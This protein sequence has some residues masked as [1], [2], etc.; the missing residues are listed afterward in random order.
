MFSILLSCRR[1][2]LLASLVVVG[3]LVLGLAATQS[4][5]EPTTAGF[6]SFFRVGGRVAHPKVYRLADLKA[7][8]AHTVAVSFQGPGGTQTHAFTGA[9]MDDVATAAAPRV[10]AD[11]KNDILRWTARVHATDNYEVVVAW[12]EFDPRFEAKQILLAYADNGQLLTDTGFA[13]LVVPNDKA[14]GR[15]VSNVNLVAFNPPRVGSDFP[16]GW[17]GED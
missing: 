9:L 7:L 5:A 8:P 11:Q 6:S 2:R 13:R 1:A 17:F 12:G 3:G 15:Y 10:D 4:A 14:G 16:F